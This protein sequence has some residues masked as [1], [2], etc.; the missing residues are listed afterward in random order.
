MKKPTDREIKEMSVTFTGAKKASILKWRWMCT[1]TKKEIIQEE[2]PECGFCDFY[3]RCRI[4]VL[5]H[6]HGYRGIEGWFAT[7][8]EKVI[9]AYW[10]LYYGEITLKQFRTVAKRMLKVIEKAKE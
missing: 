9:R 6:C 4:C 8:Y 5:K 10:K 1:A 7:L 2:W 3:G